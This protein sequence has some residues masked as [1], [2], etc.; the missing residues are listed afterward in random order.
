MSPLGVVRVE[1]TCGPDREGH[2]RGRGRAGRDTGG[3]T[4]A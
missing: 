2:P 1:Y 4:G 3:M